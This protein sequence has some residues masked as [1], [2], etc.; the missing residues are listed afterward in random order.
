[1]GIRL[2]WEIEAESEHIRG[3]GEDPESKRR[4][5]RARRRLFIVLLIALLLVGALVGAVILRLRYVDWQIEQL[6]LDTVDAEVAALRLGDQAAFLAIQRSATDDWIQRQARAFDEYQLLKREADANL[7][8]RVLDATVDRQRGRVWVEEIINGIPYGRI[9]FYWR[10]EDGWRHVPPDYTFWGSLASYTTGSV[11]VNYQTVDEVVARAVGD[12]LAGWIA[13][14]CA[15]LGCTATPALTVEIV[16]DETLPIDWSAPW[17]LR[18][19]SPFLSAARLDNPFDPAIQAETARKLSEHLVAYVKDWSPAYAADSRY[20]RAAV[21]SWLAGRFTGGSSASPLMDTLAR[22]YGDVAITRLV[23][24]AQPDSSIGVLNTAAGTTALHQLNVD[25]RDF[26]SWRLNLEH[27]LIAAR[28]E[29]GYLALYDTGDE[30][31]RAQAI[32]R[33]NASTRREQRTVVAVQL[34]SSAD[35]VPQLRT[36]VEW[37]GGVQENI[38]FRLVDGVWRRAS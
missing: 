13:S 5:R 27:E 14:G 20:L 7:T 34:E 18:M 33:F 15:V 3:A 36:A 9:W 19:P 16:P 37:E 8:G 10:Y 2:D 24:A 35:G 23:T 38:L 4:R 32:G 25:W 11:T 1:M 26:L 6:L 29:A 30:S 22:S 21:V 31:V 17:T 12:G 28:D